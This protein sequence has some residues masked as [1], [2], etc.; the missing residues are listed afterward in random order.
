MGAEGSWLLMG[1]MTGSWQHF[2]ERRWVITVH[3]IQ[4]GAK[5]P[6]RVS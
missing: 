5:R 2:S 1:F 3:G 4:K 6:M